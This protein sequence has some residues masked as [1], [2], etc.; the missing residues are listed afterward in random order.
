MPNAKAC[1]PAK[2][3][4][5]AD[6]LGSVQTASCRKWHMDSCDRLL[7]PKLA[8]ALCVGRA[9]MLLGVLF[10]SFLAFQG[11]FGGPFGVLVEPE[12]SFWLPEGAY[13]HS[14]VLSGGL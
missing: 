7:S 4:V 5:A 2:A 6:V 10:G 1:T 9:R 13:G 8:S 11:D 3:G 14:L 12:T